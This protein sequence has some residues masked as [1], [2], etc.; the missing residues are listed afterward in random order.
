MDLVRQA[1]SLIQKGDL[2]GAS[3]ICR[4]ILAGQPMHDYALYL[5]GAIEA[6]NKNLTEAAKFLGLAVRANPR[7][8][9]ALLAYGGVLLEAA[10]A[11]GGHSA[12]DALLHAV[13]DAIL[14]ALALPDIGQLFPDTDPRWKG[15]DSAVFVGEARRRMQ[16]AGWRVANL[17]ATVVL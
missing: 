8:A 6:Q 1:H 16:E 15:A 10:V 13:T 7:S 17:D 3:Q 4:T 2:K 14:G 11:V 5:L 12:A 9:E